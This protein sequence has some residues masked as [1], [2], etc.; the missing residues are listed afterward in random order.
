MDRRDRYYQLNGSG[1]KTVHS[2]LEVAGRL[3]RGL[4]S[5]TGTEDVIDDPFWYGAAAQPR[6]T[7][8][9]STP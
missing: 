9:T 6:R 4:H 1:E 2:K 7:E 5:R 8:R 3:I